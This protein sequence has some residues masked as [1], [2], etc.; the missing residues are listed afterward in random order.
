[1]LFYSLNMLLLVSRPALTGIKRRF[2]SLLRVRWLL[3]GI[4]CQCRGFLTA[5][6]GLDSARQQIPE[7]TGLPLRRYAALILDLSCMHQLYDEDA[8]S[9]QGLTGP[10]TWRRSAFRCGPPFFMGGEHAMSC[11]EEFCAITPDETRP[12]PSRHS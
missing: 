7:L 2:S 10:A 8:G 5:F 9:R 1:M 6:I 3:Q 4:E 12:L 11:A